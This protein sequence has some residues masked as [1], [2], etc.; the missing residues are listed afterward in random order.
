VGSRR[1]AER[2]RRRLGRWG[3][4]E[5]CWVASILRLCYWAAGFEVGVDPALEGG[6]RDPGVDEQGVPG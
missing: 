5:V 4:L 3:G 6:E 1:R 2:L